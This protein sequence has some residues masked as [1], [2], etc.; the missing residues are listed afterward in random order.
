MVLAFAAESHRYLQSR[1]K[2]ILRD[3][4]TVIKNGDGWAAPGTRKI[5][6]PSTRAQ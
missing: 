1:N 2:H 4:T 3:V 6:R 5:N